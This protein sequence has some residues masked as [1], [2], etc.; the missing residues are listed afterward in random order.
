MGLKFSPRFSRNFFSIYFCFFSLRR[1]FLSHLLYKGSFILNL[2]SIFLASYSFFLI[3]SSSLA[4][5]CF[6]FF[7][8]FYLSATRSALSRSRA[9]RLFSSS[10]LLLS[11]SSYLIFLWFS[12][13]WRFIYFWLFTNAIASASFC[14]FR[15]P[16]KIYAI[17][18]S[19]YLNLSCAKL[20][21]NLPIMPPIFLSRPSNS[22]NSLSGSSSS[23]SS[24]NSFS[25]IG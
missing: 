4:R 9:L 16:D 15:L 22:Y 2:S 14:L 25:S 8:S 5:C 3:Y 23:Y 20:E 7:F 6:L 13:R 10:L 21:L 17:S 19:L 24:K 12:Y 18:E 11:A 1:A